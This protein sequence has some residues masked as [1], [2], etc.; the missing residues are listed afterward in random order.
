MKKSLIA[1]SVIAMALVSGCLGVSNR[2][3]IAEVNG[4]AITRKDLEGAIDQLRRQFKEPFPEV[5]SPEYAETEKRLAQSLV[6]EE[7]F[8][9]EAERMGI[10]VSDAEVENNIDQQR[11]LSGGEE[12]L[13]RKLSEQGITLDQFKEN[14]RKSMLFQKIYAEVVKD[15][16]EFTDEEALQYY[17]Q[18]KESFKKPENCRLSHIPVADE[19]TA[20]Q[21]KARLDAGENF[22]DLAKE[23]SLDP[24]TK[25]K[26]GDL[27]ELKMKNS[28]MSPEIEQAMA[29]LTVGQVSGPVKTGDGYDVLRMDEIIP[30]R[31]LDF[32]Q[33]KESIKKQL[34]SE[35][36]SVAF[37]QWLKDAKTR[38][39]INV[40]E[41]YK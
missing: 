12:G 31:Q 23:F 8:Q 14:V 32:D 20:K 25:Q 17:N 28:G 4:H 21:V 33:V 37:Q 35:K 5:G 41:D 38:Y 13:A 1:L 16:P 15:I 39:E 30:A 36:K 40:A 24:E 26:G 9:L 2:G 10:S 29:A 27:G 18:H 3:T 34:D 19:K 22:A 6:N 11:E 7:V